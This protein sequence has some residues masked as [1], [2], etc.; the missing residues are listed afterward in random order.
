[1]SCV[2]SANK[3]M[4]FLELHPRQ[5]KISGDARDQPLGCVGRRER[6]THHTKLRYLRY[7]I[8][9]FRLVW[10]TRL[11]PFILGSI[12][13]LALFGRFHSE[14]AVF[15]SR[16]PPTHR[17]TA[18]RPYEHHESS[19]MLL[20]LALLLVWCRLSCAQPVGSVTIVSRP[21]QTRHW[22]ARGRFARARAH[23]RTHK[24]TTEDSALVHR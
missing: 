13:G 17:R 15:V 16:P 18:R 23:T 2:D 6:E 8:F 7:N 22:L 20:V 19:M 10:R 3:I 4:A 14:R 11:P 24:H 1:M 5:T 9:N 21:P 12:W